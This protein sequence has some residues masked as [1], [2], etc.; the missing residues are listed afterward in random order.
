VWG[1]SRRV[2]ALGWGGWMTPQLRCATAV[3]LLRP[4]LAAL[5]R[6]CSRAPCVPHACP[7]C[8]PCV[9]SVRVCARADS[10]G[11]ALQARPD[12]CCRLRQP[13]PA[14]YAVADG[15]A[16]RGPAAP[17]PAASHGCRPHAGVPG[18]AGGVVAQRVPGGAGPAGGPAHNAPPHPADHGAGGGAAAPTVPCP[19]LDGRGGVV[20]GGGGAAPPA[21]PTAA[22]AGGRRWRRAAPGCRCGAGRVG[23][24]GGA[25]GATGRT[26]APHRDRVKCRWSGGLCSARGASSLARAGGGSL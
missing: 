15:A 3:R 8:A 13:A 10:G 1:P 14:A 24:R 23:R 4:R 26:G 12:P 20:R 19:A 16:V 5:A 22:R 2:G 6:L 25:V 18:A 11:G 17:V 9:H 7:V 21:R